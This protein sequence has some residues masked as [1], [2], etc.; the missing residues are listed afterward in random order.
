MIA[1]SLADQIKHCIA[2]RG[3]NHNDRLPAGRDFSNEFGVTRGELRKALAE[4]E[5]D[6]TD[7]AACRARRFNRMGGIVAADAMYTP[8]TTAS[9]KTL[10]CAAR[11][12]RKTP[13]VRISGQ[14]K[15]GCWVSVTCPVPGRVATPP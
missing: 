11:T 7:L 9:W 5:S 12:L 6:G 10:P 2:K 1:V 14:S 13:C 8:I 15:T 4:L 3:F